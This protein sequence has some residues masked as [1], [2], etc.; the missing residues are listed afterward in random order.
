MKR[1]QNCGTENTNEMN[2]CVQCGA[3]LLTVPI[4]ALEQSRVPTEAFS[5]NPAPAENAAADQ[6]GEVDTVQHSFPPANQRNFAPVSPPPPKKSRKSVFWI[7]G[8]AVSLMLLLFVGVFG[9]VLFIN[10]MELKKSKPTPTPITIAS[11]TPRPSESPNAPASPTPDTS[12]TP[13]QPT[14]SFTPP[15]VPTKKG[16]FN[17]SAKEGWQLSNI[18]VVPNENFMTAAKGKISIDALNAN[19]TTNGLTDANSK[20]R[21]AYEQFPTGALLMRTRYADGKVSII[22]PV[23]APPSLGL[24]RN[25][26]DER[27]K[28]EFC[29]NDNNPGRNSGEFTVTVTLVSVPNAKK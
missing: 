11:R 29:V 25:A 16:S 17:V 14:V 2:F 21:R 7:I 13:T 4:S 18:D 20:S 6:N 1:C 15:T 19:V 8:G 24:W 26:P 5:E 3:S 28:L 12:S 27:G 23:T 9:V 22:Q 10:Y